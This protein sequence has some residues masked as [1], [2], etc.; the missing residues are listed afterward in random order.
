MFGEA[1]DVGAFRA[2]KMESLNGKLL[3][4]D[5]DNGDGICAGNT[6]FSVFNPY[7]NGDTRSPQSRIWARGFRN[8]FAV[9]IKPLEQGEQ[10]NGPGVI[11]V[12]DVGFGS[13]EE[14]NTITHGGM[15]M[16]WPCWEGGYPMP[17]H[18]DSIYDPLTGANS[19]GI[20]RPIDPN[21]GHPINCAYMYANITTDMPFFFHTRYPQGSGLAGKELEWLGQGF[22]GNA[23]AG[24][25][26]YTG[27]SYP[28]AYQNAIF[29]LDY[30]QRWIRVL[31]RDAASGKYTYGNHFLTIPDSIL[32]LKTDPVSGDIFYNRNLNG[33][34]HRI[35]YVAANVTVPPAPVATANAT[36]GILPMTVQFSLDG[37]DEHDLNKITSIKWNFGDGKTATLPNPVYTYTQEGTYNATVTVTTSAGSSATAWIMMYPSATNKPPT[38]R[39]IQPAPSDSYYFYEINETLTFDCEVDDE[40]PSKLTYKWELEILHLNHIHTDQ[41]D[42][43]TKSFNSSMTN[44]GASHAGERANER[45]ILTVTDEFGATAK[46]VAYYS[47]KEFMQLHFQDGVTVGNSAPVAVLNV[48]G[49][50]PYTAGQ[51]IRFT[52]ISSTDADM[53]YLL[54]SWDFGD[55]TTTSDTTAP[56]HFYNT[57]GYYLVTLTVS[58][59]WGWTDQTGVWLTVLNADGSKPAGVAPNNVIPTGSNQPEYTFEEAQES[60]SSSQQTGDDTDTNSNSTNII[61]T[62]TDSETTND[63]ASSDDMNS[64]DE[65]ASDT[66]IPAGGS[67]STQNIDSSNNSSIDITPST[68]SIARV[69]QFI[70]LLVIL[71]ISL[72]AN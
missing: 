2:Q 72:S 12:G 20:I 33:D 11:L 17:V 16:G 32:T 7:C 15:N 55:N 46:D 34:V 41:A 61:D 23:I 36:H 28:A 18:R 53:D 47:E 66:N 70:V 6:K 58:D 65:S 35:R 27:T 40:N 37:T 68:A 31:H 69:S 56:T 4:L 14:V 42:F 49:Y 30:G 24:V 8:P 44:L 52:G 5:P 26:T 1:L 3:R 10:I 25:A 22:L 21:T 57:G 38:V 59:N 63:S 13:Y 50:Q 48:S 60:S 62:T 29:F 43:Y 71:V 51:L 45:F 54:Y 64:S 39:I 67:S 19:A 9:N